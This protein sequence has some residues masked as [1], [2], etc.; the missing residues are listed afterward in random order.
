MT[1]CGKCLEG[2]GFQKPKID[3]T[4]VQW[5]RPSPA[6]YCNR[7]MMKTLVFGLVM[8]ISFTNCHFQGSLNYHAKISVN[9]GHADYVADVPSR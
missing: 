3:Q 4:D 6:V 5:E 7:V 1:T 9:R 2:A 8:S